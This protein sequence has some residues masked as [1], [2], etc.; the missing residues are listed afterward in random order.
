MVLKSAFKK[1]TMLIGLQFLVITSLF[2]QLATS[3][4]GELIYTIKKIDVNNLQSGFGN[5]NPNTEE[6]LILYAKD[7]LIKRVHFNSENGIQESIEHLSY[8]K[9]ILLLSID[10]VKYA[11]QL[12]REQTNDQKYPDSTYKLS[13]KCFPKIAFAGLK[14]KPMLLS[15]PM[16]SND[17]YMVQ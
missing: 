9:K 6:K 3:F 1:T 16:L 17:L 2:G 11:V 14:G 8:G 4:S 7:S 12:P 10:T 13:K 5:D 15:H